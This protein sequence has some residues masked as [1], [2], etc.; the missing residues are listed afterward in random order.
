MDTKQMIKSYKKR[1]FKFWMPAIVLLI[2]SLV[3]VAIGII[4]R[5]NLGYL[6][7]QALILIGQIF[8]VLAVLLFMIVEPLRTYFKR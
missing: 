1:R 3:L 7:S 6:W 8:S 4:F 5:G 2:I